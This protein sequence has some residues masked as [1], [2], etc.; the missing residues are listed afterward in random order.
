MPITLYFF[1][2]KITLNLLFD[3]MEHFEMIISQTMI[4]K[5]SD[6]TNSIITNME[7]LD[8][9]V[10]RIVDFVNLKKEFRLLTCQQSDVL[11]KIWGVQGLRS[12]DNYN[13]WITNIIYLVIEG[14]ESDIC[15]ISDICP[16][17]TIKYQLAIV[18]KYLLEHCPI[19]KVKT[20]HRCKNCDQGYCGR[21]HQIEHRKDHK[22][23]CKKI[24]LISKV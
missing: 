7:Q 3:S 23:K 6:S 14:I 24:T 13:I 17:E 16:K 21:E 1:Y 18:N 5:L 15:H 20:K 11:K 19:C 12:D 2:K 9:L 4:N 10:N 22:I 8:N